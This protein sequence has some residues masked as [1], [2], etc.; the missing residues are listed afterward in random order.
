MDSVVH[1]ATGADGAMSG[2]ALREAVNKAKAD[3]KTPLYVNATAGTTVFGAF[4]HFNDIADVC[5]SE[6]MWMHVDVRI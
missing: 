4:D 6:G 5:E 3:G 2:D 1:V